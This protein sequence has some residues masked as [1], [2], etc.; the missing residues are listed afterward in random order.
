MGLFRRKPAT[1]DAPSVPFTSTHQTVV[2]EADRDRA[3]RIIRR[4]LIEQSLLEHEDRNDEMN[5]VLLDVMKALAMPSPLG[6]RSSVPVVP[7]RS[8]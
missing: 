3:A 1:T 6:V 5:D 7:G 4:V 2:L 8:S